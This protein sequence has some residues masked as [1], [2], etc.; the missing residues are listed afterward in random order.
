M[1]PKTLLKTFKAVHLLI[2]FLA[3]ILFSPSPRAKPGEVASGINFVD[4]DIRDVAKA[5]AMANDVNIVVDADV[6]CKVTMYLGEMEL[7]KMLQILT[8]SYNLAIIK[9]GGVYRIKKSYQIVVSRIELSGN[10]IKIISVANKDVNEFIRE[11]SNKARLNIVGEKGLTGTITGELNNINLHKG[12]STLFTMN[13]YEF[14]KK[15]GVYTVSQ[16]EDEESEKRRMPVKKKSQKFDLT[17]EDTLISLALVN[18]DLN[19]VLKEISEQCELDMIIY[20]QLKG[21]VNAN[22]VN[23]PVFKAISLL[24]AGTRYTFAVHDDILMIG[25]KQA[26]SESGQALSKTELIHLNHIKADD[27]PK[28]LPKSIP[29][30]NINVIKEQNAILVNG[31]NQLIDKVRDFVSTIDLPTPQICI[32]AVVVEFSLEIKKEVGIKW[33][34]ISDSA[35]GI[36]YLPAFNHNINKKSGE[37]FLRGAEKNLGLKVGMLGKLPDNFIM[38]L[39]AMEDD[40]KA[41]ILARPK[42]ITLNG[43]KASINLDKSSYFKIEGGT[44]LNRFVRFQAINSGIKLEFTPWISSGGQITVEIAPDISE[45]LPS[46]TQDGYPDVT[47]RN[48]KTTVRLNDG[49]TMVLG[50]LINASDNFTISKIP[51]LG[52]IPIIGRLF[53]FKSKFKNRTELII[54]VTPHIVNSVDTVNLEDE[55]EKYKKIMDIPK[56]KRKIYNSEEE[57]DKEW[58]EEK[59][60]K[61]EK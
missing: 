34:G 18:A 38:T 9:E 55:L 24:L 27:L 16:G 10:M 28:I 26:S 58:L 45:A 2:I 42:L 5:I 54:Y 4:T 39:R 23:L 30:A 56:K 48:V 46:N 43:N 31:T 51:L 8:K 49:E 32:E 60:I 20:E 52:S 17:L 1:N 61:N 15:R 35:S 53:Q 41:N 7:E 29:S 59:K 50:G 44:D 13:N 3:L 33:A 22:F 12:L 47:S 25:D 11:V 14:K 6:E 36:S 57:T 19:E 40:K 21:V 37:G